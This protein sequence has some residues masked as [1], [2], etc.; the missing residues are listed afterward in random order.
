MTQEN[1]EQPAKN[2]WALSFGISDQVPA[3]QLKIVKEIESAK[4]DKPVF[5]K[6][7]KKY[8]PKKTVIRVPKSERDKFNSLCLRL[9]EKGYG[10]KR[11]IKIAKRLKILSYCSFGTYQDYITKVRKKNGFRDKRIKEG[12][13]QRRVIRLKNKGLPDGD[14]AQILGIDVRE[15]GNRITQERYR[16]TGKGINRKAM[17]Y[18]ELFNQGLKIY[19]IAERVGV[20]EPSALRQ[21]NRYKALGYIK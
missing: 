8:K 12:S 9:L 16:A 4:A 5:G 14:I 2:T 15:V 10:N 18:I 1:I 11:I 17:Q 3:E 7:E 19:Q 20:Q 13:T 21:I 6:F